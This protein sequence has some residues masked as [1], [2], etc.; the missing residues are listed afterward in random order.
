MADQMD[1]LRAT[2][3]DLAA[4]ARRLQAIEEEKRGM[5]AGDPRL[6]TLAEEAERLTLRMTPKAHA[7]RELAEEVSSEA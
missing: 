4:D 7:E 5:E 3:D 6:R 2:A 1:D